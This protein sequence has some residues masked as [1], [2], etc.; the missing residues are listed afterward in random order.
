MVHPRF[1]IAAFCAVWLAVPA[2]A[3]VGPAEDARAL[4][5]RIDQLIAARWSAEKVTPAPLADDGAFLRR[6]SLDAIGRIPSVAETRRFL[7]DPASAKR[8]RAVERLLNSP[9]YV[10]HFSNIW[11]DLLLPEANADFQQRF[12]SANIERWL[13]KEFADDVPYDRM[14][15]DLLTLPLKAN[16][17]QMFY[18]PRSGD[19]SPMAF[20]ASKLGKPENLAATTARLFLGVRLEC[21]QCH[22]HPFG[23]WTREQFWGQ[24]AFFGGI[25]AQ[26]D[27]GIYSPLSEVA[28]R[29]ELAIPGTERVAQAR[30]LDGKEPRWSYKV[31]ARTTLADWMTA[32]DN[33]FFARAAVNRLW[34][35]FFGVGI[36][37]PVDD[38]SDQNKP[39]HPELLDE[40][41]RQFAGHDF[42]QRFLIRA[43][44]L[45]KTYQLSSVHPGP[46]QPD[47]RLFAHMPV[48]G[49]SADQLFESFQLA[50]GTAN[51]NRDQRR[52]AFNPDTLSFE[53]KFANQEKRTEYQTSIPQ[54]LALMN[55]KMVANATNP[56]KGEFLAAVLNAP[57]LD[58][59]GRI[60]T[61]YLAT[62]SRKPQ[63][64]EAERFHRHI[65][66]AGA[67]RENDALADV[68]WTLLN[69]P[70]FFLNH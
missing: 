64:E 59:D 67:G 13:R 5:A 29:R 54:A 16:Q 33:P 25:R 21:A 30:F 10:T 20:Y 22:N 57:F 31:S 4:A 63:P 42:D 52:F 17:Q 27:N 2:W 24:A 8:E 62:L 61:L 34:A 15:R 18:N 56:Q 6:L 69:S 7:A 11:R 1:W 40:L 60:E 19:P 14:V 36:V 46:V 32:K 43:I 35:H 55:S 58:T 70:E 41:A 37:E 53:A 28:D 47:I 45:S 51:V 48:K 39:S 23:K 65:A 44:A 3:D 50:T 66:K 38:L 12:L 49:L 26:G 9:G 68:F